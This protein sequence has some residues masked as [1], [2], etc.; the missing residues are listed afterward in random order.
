MTVRLLSFLMLFC[1]A[2]PVYPVDTPLEF[3]NP[4]QSQR[5]HHLI[6]QLRCLVCQN[7]SLE[8]SHADLAQDLRQEVQQMILAGRSNQDIIG[9]L[10]ERYGDFVLYLPPLKEST[11]VLWLAP[12]LVLLFAVVAI[13]FFVRGHSAD[14]VPELDREAQ[15]RLSRLL[16][17]VKERD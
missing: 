4:E 3:N 17:D 13:L 9:F 6:K 11:L 15:R 14:R 12:F 10:V 5:Y 1:L 2:A 8:D 16:N 7:Q